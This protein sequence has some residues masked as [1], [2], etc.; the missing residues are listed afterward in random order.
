M[1][2]RLQDVHGLELNPLLV[3]VFAATS[4]FS[5]KD[6]PANITE[7][8]KKF[9]EMMLG[10][11][12]ASKGLSQQFHAPLKDFLLKQVAFE[13]HRRQVTSLPVDELRRMISDALNARGYSA[14]ISQL[15][16][17]MIER[18]GLFRTVGEAVEFRH[19]LLQ[20]FFAGRGI[21]SAEMLETVVAEEWWQ[22]AIVFYFGEHPDDVRGLH[23]IQAA[24]LPRTDAERYRSAITLGLALQACYLVEVKNRAEILGWITQV[25]ARSKTGFVEGGVATG[26]PPLMAFIW[27]YMFG[28]D[29]V[30]CNLP[31]SV[32]ESIRIELLEQASTS[33]ESDTI[34]FWEIVSGIECGLTNRVETLIR[35]FRP[36]DL[37]LLFGVYISLRFV[38][39]LR[40]SS[41]AEKAAAKRLAD[42]LHEHVRPVA[43]EFNKEFKSV[44]IELRR[45]EIKEVAPMLLPASSDDD[46]PSET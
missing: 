7:L 45:G 21:P 33:D 28:R 3:T 4:D 34:N 11:W 32:R 6:I 44:L 18:S 12:D 30:A 1:L 26:V 39:H 31:D 22:R 29:G 43:E 35:R 16:D 9:T 14:D 36:S 41:S 27:Y 20:E 25:V 19:L 23:A 13:M 2:R 38:E 15:W 42:R 37:R 46:E 17:E 40:I 8:F 5:R 10:R 24:V